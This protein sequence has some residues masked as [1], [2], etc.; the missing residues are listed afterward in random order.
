MIFL[1]F[2]TKHKRKR[3]KEI[4]YFNN[5]E[6]FKTI[7]KE[8]YEIKYLT[9]FFYSNREMKEL[10]KEN[11]IKIADVTILYLLEYKSIEGKKR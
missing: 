1:F 5:I 7:I 11:I 3:I 4:I 9:P 10:I 8:K 2:L 6:E